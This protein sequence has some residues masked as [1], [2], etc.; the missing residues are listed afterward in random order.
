MFVQLAKAVL[1]PSLVLIMTGGGLVE[2]A[3][4]PDDQHTHRL[5]CGVCLLA[6]PFVLPRN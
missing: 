1:Y 2:R 5:P 4:V 6:R 3:G